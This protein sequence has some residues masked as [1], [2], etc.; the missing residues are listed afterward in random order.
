MDDLLRSALFRLEPE[1]SHHTALRLLAAAVAVPGGEALLRALYAPRQQRPVE[2]IGLRFP[3]AVGLAAGYDKNA[4]AWRGLAALGLGH[5]ELGTVTPEPQSGNPAPRVFRLA[6]ERCLINRLGFP[7]VGARVVLPRLRGARGRG[8]VIGINLGKNKDT[9]LEEAARDYVS[10]VHSFA[11]E[12]DYLTVNVSS[13]NTP[14]LRALQTGEALCALLL[15]V[16]QARDEEVARLGRSVPVLVKLS[17]DL[18]D[19]DLDDALQA[20]FDAGID[21]VIATNTTLSREGVRDPQAREPGGLSGAAL[22]ER[23]TRMVRTI[24]QRAGDRLPLIGVG[25]IM[26]A[27]DARA[28]LD[29][30]ADLVQLYT[31]LVYGG[32]ALVRRI[33]EALA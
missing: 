27:V 18:E 29:A 8:V 12:A 14:G 2:L 7:S 4:T 5:L 23:S 3:N 31:G 26:D 21:G 22:T 24:R 13:P 25:G 16:R 10:L 1:V 11:A 9:P 6:D 15:Q 20:V 32:P 33:V 30:G 28:R 19:A 17:P